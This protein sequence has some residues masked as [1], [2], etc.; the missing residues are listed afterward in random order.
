MWAPIFS[1]NGRNVSEALDAYIKKLQLFKKIIDEND[2]K[3]SHSLMKEANEIRRIL[4]GILKS[5]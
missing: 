1:Q 5:E 3:S 2:E 4:T